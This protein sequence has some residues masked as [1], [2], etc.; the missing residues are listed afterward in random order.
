MPTVK[1]VFEG[2]EKGFDKEE[3]GDWEAIIQYAV[4][5]DGGGNW[6]MSVKDGACSVVEGT[7]DAA[8]ATLETDAETWI[9]IADGSVEPTS[10]FMMGK[11]RIQGNMGD[12]MKAQKVIKRENA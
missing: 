5:G 10:A 3:A 12:V 8:T 7:N 6:V 1:E 4:E 9:G 11:I 2:M